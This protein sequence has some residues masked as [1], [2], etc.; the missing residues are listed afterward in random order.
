MLQQELEEEGLGAFSQLQEQMGVVMQQ[1]PPAPRLLCIHARLIPLQASSKMA[2]LKEEN[3]LLKARVAQ[4]QQPKQE[5]A[6]A[7]AAGSSSARTASHAAPELD[8][9][10]D[11]EAASE[12]T[13]S[14]GEDSRR[15]SCVSA[16]ELSR[17]SVADSSCGV[18]RD[19]SM[20][21]DESG[22]ASML[23]ALDR[24]AAESSVAECPLATCGSSDQASAPPAP[25][26]AMMLQPAAASAA[27]VPS[28]VDD[29]P[30]LAADAAPVLAAD[31]EI[32]GE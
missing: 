29:A 28:V 19:A 6:A 10:N 30:A 7:A 3:E 22:D 23:S 14:V 13:G 25:A 5:P 24:S 16:L 32:A 11:S 12:C 18:S 17:D 8:C 1:V 20:C 9:L 15:S 2:A 27:T 26:P 4:L 31:A 21:E